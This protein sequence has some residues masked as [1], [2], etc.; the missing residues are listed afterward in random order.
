[1]KVTKIEVDKISYTYKYLL[2]VNLCNGES[3][4][5]DNC[6]R[7]KEEYDIY[8]LKQ[9]DRELEIVKENGVWK[10]SKIMVRGRCDYLYKIGE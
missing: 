7:S 6:Y 5:T 8:S 3:N 4:V 9:D 1:M 2:P 10:I